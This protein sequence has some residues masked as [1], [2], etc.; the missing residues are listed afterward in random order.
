MRINT[1]LVL[2]F[3]CLFFL[4]ASCSQTPTEA[5]KELTARG[6]PFT[7]DA[8]IEFSENG[9]QSVVELFIIGDIN[10]NAASKASGST[11]LIAAASKGRTDIAHMLIAAGANV[12]LAGAQHLGTPLEAAVWGG[13]YITT[14]KLL[15]EHGATVNDQ[16]IYLAVQDKHIDA[17]KYFIDHV[18]KEKET[19][20]KYLIFAVETKQIEIA[21]LIIDMGADPNLA[22]SENG[23]TALQIAKLNG[24]RNMVEML[25]KHGSKQ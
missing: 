16:V 10:V 19:L 8:F 9:N 20:N 5:R 15:V 4:V 7:T 21:L 6:I 18:G 23:L 2:T 22:V 1:I 25:I 11:P 14:I 3:A 24:D 12:D 13:G 17:V